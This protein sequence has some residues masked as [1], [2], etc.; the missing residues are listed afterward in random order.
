MTYLGIDNKKDGNIKFETSQCCQ[1]PVSGQVRIGGYTPATKDFTFSVTSVKE[2]GK[3]DKTTTYY[4]SVSADEVWRIEKN[5]RLVVPK[6]TNRATAQLENILN[7]D[8]NVVVLQKFKKV[9]FEVCYILHSDSRWKWCLYLTLKN[10]KLLVSVL[11]LI[12][13]VVILMIF[14]KKL[15]K[16]LMINLKI[17]LV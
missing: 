3:K 15:M 4:S 14:M 17:P 1:K 11:G 13:L 9:P 6:R 10:M 12:I 7:D 5:L 2:S 16:N 8:S